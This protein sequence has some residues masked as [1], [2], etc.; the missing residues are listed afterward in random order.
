MQT[1]PPLVDAATVQTVATALAAIAMAAVWVGGRIR[2]MGA[3]DP[4]APKPAQIGQV[5][6]PAQIVPTTDFLLGELVAARQLLITE[7]TQRTEAEASA[8]SRIKR[9]EDRVAMLE[10]Q[11]ATRDKLVA[12][13][14]EQLRASGAPVPA[15][16]LRAVSA[17][18]ANLMA[19]QQATPDGQARSWLAD[20]FSL[21]D[22]GVLAS[23]ALGIP[24]D[25]ING[26]DP[27][28]YAD[29]MIHYA[30]RRGQMDQL[31]RA[32][33]AARPRVPAPWDES[34]G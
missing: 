7:K 13:L 3:N 27:A 17:E 1:A 25:A 32:A 21:V 20:H 10:D 8:E 28:A 2:R 34:G 22:L 30:R 23:D 9:L 6:A 33:R 24:P 26:Q 31:L 11:L 15:S 12:M 4:A 16:A 29:A 5:P 14:V 19:N 18:V